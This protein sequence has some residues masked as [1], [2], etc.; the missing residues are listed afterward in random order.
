MSRYARISRDKREAIRKR[1]SSGRFIMKDIAREFNI[2]VSSVWYIINNGFSVLPRMEA[3]T[4]EPYVCSTFGCGRILT[5]T[6]RLYGK[7]CVN[8]SNFLIT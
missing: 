2:S 6:E 8:H 7:K 1:Y 3:P 4:K 5:R